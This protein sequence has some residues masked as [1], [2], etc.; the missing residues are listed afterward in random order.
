MRRIGVVSAARSDYG[1]YRPILDELAQHPSVEVVLFV[2]SAHLLEATGRTAGEIQQDQHAVIVTVDF[3]IDADTPFAMA[4]G[5]G[6]GVSAF[7]NAFQRHPLDLLVVLGDRF[8]MLAASLASLPFNLPLVHLHGGEVT[9]GAIDDGIRHALTKLSHLHMVSNVEHARRLLQMGEEPW[10]VTVSGAPGLD[11][12]RTVERLPIEEVSRRLGVDASRAFLLLTFHPPSRD[13]STALD[14]LSEVV[15]GVDASGLPVVV[16]GSGIEV[17][18]FEFNRALIE[19]CQRRSKA[20]FHSSL[21][22]SMY[23]NAMARAAAVVGN[24]SS[25]LI[26][27]PSFERPAVN[28]GERQRGRARGSNVIDVPADRRQIALAIERALSDDFRQ[29]LV[30]M[31]NPY[32]DGRA[33]PR[34]VGRLVHQPLDQRLLEKKFHEF[35]GHPTQTEEFSWTSS[36]WVQGD[37]PR[38]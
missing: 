28:I 19:F 25:G 14:Q 21:G 31:R 37:T 36:D 1:I 15:A 24:S 26:E 10:R 8:E 5:A 13:P 16:T 6:A 27:A 4:H 12:I 38:S 20:Q 18:G 32:G 29:T 3:P 11:A 34:I 17:H 2:T 9:E 30:G 22:Q 33:A 7:A 35:A 23:F